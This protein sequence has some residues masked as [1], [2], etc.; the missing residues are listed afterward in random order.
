MHCPR[1]DGV[2]CAVFGDVSARQVAGGSNPSVHAQRIMNLRKPLKGGFSLGHR[3][4]TDLAL[5]GPGQCRV[6]LRS[7]R[8]VLIPVSPG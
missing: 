7:A 4:V 3:I 6:G 2:R 8:G 5:K 1:R